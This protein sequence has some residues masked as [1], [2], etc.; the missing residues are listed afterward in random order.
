MEAEQDP[1]GWPAQVSTALN[2]PG[3]QHMPA[4]ARYVVL[5]H[6]S[7]GDDAL[8]TI[9]AAFARDVS[10]CRRLVVFTP[11]DVSPTLPFL[12][13]SPSGGELTTAPHA[14]ITAIINRHLSQDLARAFDAPDITHVAVERE[15]ERLANE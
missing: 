3:V 7:G 6:P 8:K 5:V 13:L 11:S 12:P 15:I 4:W 2:A 1:N 9:A 14:D 10:K